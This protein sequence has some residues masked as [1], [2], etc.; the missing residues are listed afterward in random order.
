[1]Q[2]NK[3]IINAFL[4]CKGREEI[5][6]SSIDEKILKNID[7]DNQ[8]YLVF[9]GKKLSSPNYEYVDITVNPFE[10]VTVTQS[11]TLRSYKDIDSYM[12]QLFEGYSVYL[13]VNETLEQGDMLYRSSLLHSALRNS[14]KDYLIASV[15][16]IL[17]TLAVT[18]FLCIISG[19]RKDGSIKLTFFDKIPFIINLAITGFLGVGTLGIAY[20]L[21]DEYSR[22]LTPTY[23]DIYYY[24]GTIQPYFFYKLSAVFIVL[25][26]LVLMVFIL[27]IVRNVKAKTLKDRFMLP[28]IAKF[29]SAKI[30]RLNEASNVLKHKSKY[31]LFNLFICFVFDVN[32]SSLHGIRWSCSDTDS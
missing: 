17:L 5:D 7:K 30:K 13:K 22:V 21:I 25:C 8:F 28:K 19:K 27:Y 1:M 14:C 32:Y 24:N 18:V 12:Q 29:L 20:M 10:Q 16:F 15:I 6:F 2:I 23:N 11:L 26:V 4:F 31:C 3:L 9:D